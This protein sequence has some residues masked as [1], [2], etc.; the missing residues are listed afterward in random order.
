MRGKKII[1]NREAILALGA[2]DGNAACRTVTAVRLPGQ[3][4]SGGR[5]ISE[6]FCLESQAGESN[7]RPVK[8]TE[9]FSAFFRRPS[10]FDA[11]DWVP[12]QEGDRRITD[13]LPSVW[14]GE[15]R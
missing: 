8:K 12:P 6:W 5:A 9:E 7:R 14:R 13:K 1:Q 4:V 3:A 10:R 11:E 2:E 15:A